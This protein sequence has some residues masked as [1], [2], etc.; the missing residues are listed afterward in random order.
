M[1]IEIEKQAASRL[2]NDIN[3]ML[4]GYAGS[5][6]FMEVCGTHT[7]A[8]HSSGV[9][10]LLNKQIS[11]VSGPGCPVCVTEKL[12]IDQAMFLAEHFGVCLITFGDLIRVPGSNGSLADLRSR[13]YSVKVVYSPMDSIEI[14]LELAPR[15]VVFLGIG[16]ETTIPTVAVTVKTA[17]ERQVDNLFILPAFKTIHEPLKILASNKDLTGFLLPGHVS[18]IIGVDCYDYLVKDFK[19]PGVVAGFE[20]LDILYAMRSL[21]QMT[22]SGEPGIENNYRTVVRSEGNVFARKLIDEVFE[23][24]DA[25]WRGLGLIKGSGLAFKPPYDDFD[26][27]KRFPMQLPDAPDDPR[28]KCARILTGALTPNQCGLFGKEC[29]P[30]TPVGPCM[31]SSEGTCAAYYKYGGI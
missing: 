18:A 9:K 19:K 20:G 1:K 11:L 15:P 29:V 24:A 6:K 8:I 10:S 13:G 7:M 30:E 31:V 21:V 2:S 12:F 26:A 16:F 27:L 17:F 3:S 5:M 14:A 22:V 28:C 23:P 25:S 4:R